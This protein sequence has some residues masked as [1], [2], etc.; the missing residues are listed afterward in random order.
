MSLL[1][2]S[3]SFPVPHHVFRTQVIRSNR[4]LYLNSLKNSYINKLDDI[5]SEGVLNE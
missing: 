3:F 4:D 5:G 2:N 1:Q